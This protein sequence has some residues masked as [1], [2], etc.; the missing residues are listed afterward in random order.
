M[1]SGSSRTKQLFR[2]HLPRVPLQPT[3]LLGRE[4]HLATVHQLLLRP[5]VRLITLPGPPGVGK[6]RLALEARASLAEWYRD[7]AVFVE[8]A[9]VRDP[10]RV[11]QTI[12]STLGLWE[13][14]TRPS[15]EQLREKELM[16]LLDNFEHLTDVA[17]Q[18]GAPLAFCPI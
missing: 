17:S 12:A 8:L 18:I 13:A 9:P 4:R 6:T 3:P 14:S 5:E 11:T 15:E 16:L 7:G 10:A 1:A 2:P